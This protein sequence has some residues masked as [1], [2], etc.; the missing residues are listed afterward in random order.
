VAQL[1]KKL[2]AAE[3]KLGASA[4]VGGWRVEWGKSSSIHLDPDVN[5]SGLKS[6]V[7]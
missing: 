7:L 3:K 6:L 5:P 4:K 1:T 2:E